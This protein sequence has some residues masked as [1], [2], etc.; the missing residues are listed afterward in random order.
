MRTIL[1][2]VC[3]LVAVPAFAQSDEWQRERDALAM[4]CGHVDLGAIPACSIALATLSPVHVSLGTIAPQNKKSD[5]ARDRRPDRGSRPVA[6]QLERRCRRCR[7]RGVARRHVHERH[8]GQCRVTCDRCSDTRS[9]RAGTRSPGGVFDLLADDVA[10]Q[11]VVLWF[12]P[13]ANRGGG[14]DLDD[15]SDSR[16]RASDRAAE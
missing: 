8:P 14:I 7:G 10:R 15:A 11:A 1:P 5:R 6:Y 12:W 2:I 3:L 9:S 16:G 4:A 13:R